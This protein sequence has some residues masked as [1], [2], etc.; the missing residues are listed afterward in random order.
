MVRRADGT[1]AGSAVLLDTCLRNAIAWLRWLPA[2]QLVQ[3]ATQ[4]PADLLGLPHKGR[5]AVGA[6]ADLVVLD[7]DWHVLQTIIGGR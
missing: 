3:M 6:D 2:A 7:R 4:T 5:I 1:L